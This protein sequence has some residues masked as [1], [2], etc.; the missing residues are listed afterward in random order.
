M[1]QPA[2]APADLSK[3]DSRTPHVLAR[4]SRRRLLRWRQGRLLRKYMLTFMLV[5]SGAVLTSGVVQAYSSFQETQSALGRIQLANATD[6]ATRIQGF[7]D[8]TT[9]IIRGGT[10]PAYVDPP[11]INQLGADFNRIMR[12]A[13]AISEISYLDALC[14]ERVFNSRT[15]QNRVYSEPVGAPDRS[16]DPRCTEAK[17][18][19]VYYS[20][21]TFRSDSEPYMS[22]AVAQAEGRGGV[23]VADVNLK[24]IWQ[25]VQSIKMSHGTVYALDSSG[26]LIAHP[27]IN[28]VLRKTD[29]SASPQFQRARLEQNKP[30]WQVVGGLTGGQ[31][32]SAYNFF[33][34]PGWYVFVDQPVEEA[35]GPLFESLFRTVV[36]LVIGLAISFVVSLFLASSLVRPIQVLQAAAEKIGLGAL[37][38]R[39]QIRTGDE[40]ETLADE[41]N[42]MT[43]QLRESYANLE[44][45]VTER[46]AQLAL[47]TREAQEAR[48]K[49]LEAD[50][51]KTVFL[52]SMSHELRTPLNAIIGYSELLQEE[53]ADQGQDNFAQDLGR[54]NTSGKYLLTLINDILDLSKIIAGKM[55]LYLESFEL[56]ALIRDIES[57]VQ[58]L[59]GKNDNRLMVLRNPE[60]LGPMRADLTRVRQCLFNLLSNAA[61]FTRQ[62]TITLEVSRHRSGEDIRAESVVFRVSDTGIG[63]T[64]EQISRLFQ[65]FN[66]AD[67]SISSRFGGTGLGLAI[68][69]RLC[70]IMGGDVTV[71]SEVGKGSTFTIVLPAAAPSTPSTSNGD[72]ASNEGTASDADSELHAAKATDGAETA[73]GGQE[74]GPASDPTL[75]LHAAKAPEAASTP[76]PAGRGRVLVVDDDETTRDL[77]RR[78]LESEG[79][80]VAL[81]SSGAEG[82]RLAKSLR[83]DVMT[84]DVLMPEMD[85]WTVLTA[86]KS[87]AELAGIPVVMLTIVEDK[88]KGYALG[89]SDYLTKPVDRDRL[90]AVLDRY[91]HNHI[92]PRVLVVED[93]ASARQLMR[94]IL[95]REGWEVVEAENGRAALA[96]TEEQRPDLILLDLL[97]PEM[98][99]FELAEA[100]RGHEQWRDIPI[101]VVTA[102]DLTAEDRVRLNDYIERIFQKGAYTREELLGE[103]RRLVLARAPGS[104][105]R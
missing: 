31:V 82:L 89:A 58:P 44:W 47:A 15:A 6:A 62:G 100:L 95:E 39:I 48:D 41:F 59:L 86:L 101:V 2:S 63:M 96:K 74:Q 25:I 16:D 84:L 50:R 18:H 53:A 7:I 102:K 81:A 77:L 92:S 20:P 29:L 87:D 78:S 32:V 10:P 49:A 17:A 94:H 34:P 83:P 11:P 61:K 76:A 88:G 104:V 13:L 4:P 40:L 60:N 5:V 3:P 85:G 72:Q 103:V 51:A 1:S 64:A 68:T 79:F 69:K 56:N 105:R 46:T 65:A 57:T 45:K 90:A 19:K 55:D 98:D 42:Q 91:R 26:Y 97:M 23:I 54:I 70:Q 37:D 22:I 27:D 66:Q 52:A 35:F 67:T 73:A 30:Q 38:Q 28:L 80:Q 33:D 93:D 43:A 9:G 36:L 12:Q 71:A 8:Q 75:E 14:R 99:G 24:L 21:V